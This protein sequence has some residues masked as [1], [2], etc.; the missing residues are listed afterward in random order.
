MRDLLA[1]SPLPWEERATVA[2]SG[3]YTFE[4]V[5]TQWD[6]ELEGF[7]LAHCLGTKDAHEFNLNHEVFS[8]RQADTGIPHATILCVKKGKSSPYGRCSD[9]GTHKPFRPRKDGY[10]LRV[11]QV[12]GR[13]DVLA[14]PEFLGLAMRWYVFGGGKP[15]ISLELLQEYAARKGD[16]DDL[17]HYCGLLDE[18][19][20]EYNWAHWRKEEHAQV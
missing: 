19:T 17:Y 3:A 1:E 2:K 12:R 7:L 16:D 5:R 11:L 14:K 8:I 6:Y 10:K 18:R 20:N 13:N 15:R 9:L 4:R